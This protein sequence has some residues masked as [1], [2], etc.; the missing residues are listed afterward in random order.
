[1]SVA[2]RGSL[3]D[4]GLGEVLQLIGQQRKTGVLEVELDHG[5]IE[6]HFDAGAV[7]F[8]APR[9]G[10][11]GGALGE[12]L[13]RCGVLDG[14]TVARIEEERHLELRSF[15]SHAVASGAV[16]A[17]ELGSVADLLTRETIFELLQCRSGAFRFR[18]CEVDTGIPGA[19]HL[20]A[21]QLLM[22]G[23]RMLDEWRAVRPRV[24]EPGSLL[25]RL[26]GSDA[27]LSERAAR[28]L[29]AVADGPRTV[30]EAIDRSR[31][32]TFEGG[33]A[34]VELLD[35]GLVDAAGSGSPA[36]PDGDLPPPP[37]PK[38]FSLAAALVLAALAVLAGAAWWPRAAPPGLPIPEAATGPDGLAL[39]R[40]R[41]AVDAWR[42]AT[43]AWP[44]SLADLV[45]VGLLP[46][47]ALTTRDG[48]PYYYR[49]RGDAA[50]VLPPES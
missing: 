45:E 3:E 49:R 46:P 12:M 5:P 11:D 16:P 42:V 44:A 50:L 24:P 39:L 33:R 29:A 23:L 13:V 4:F 30:A 41:S 38:G 32:G 2:L 19:S 25:R 17:E 34:L 10:G 48:R 35:R 14:E 20:P 18:S 40:V 47:D 43:G 7:V 15:A 6:V 36:T 1:M 8:A 21:E 27:G 22:D 9:T 28:L 26:P 31:L 37:E